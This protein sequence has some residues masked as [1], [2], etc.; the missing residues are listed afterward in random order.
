M[1]VATLQFWA[2]SPPHN[3]KS[4]S[5]DLGCLGYGSLGFG[6]ESNRW[7]CPE[8]LDLLYVIETVEVFTRGVNE[9]RHAVQI[10][11]NDFVVF[12]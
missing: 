8:L 12:C 1:G 10:C 7:G 4:H 5:M 2:E 3:P 11:I 6:G 9:E